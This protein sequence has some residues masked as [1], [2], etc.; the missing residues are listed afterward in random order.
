M[1]FLTQNQH[2]GFVYSV[3]KCTLF[4]SIFKGPFA[5][6]I[7]VQYHTGDRDN[8]KTLVSKQVFG[9]DEFGIAQFFNPL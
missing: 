4:F 6:T 5:L 7:Q 1:W 2:L 9:N 8:I 3:I